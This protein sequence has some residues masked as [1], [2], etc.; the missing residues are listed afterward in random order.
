MNTTTLVLQRLGRNSDVLLAMGVFGLI[1]VM[2]VPLPSWVLDIL[3]AASF[4]S[5]I[6]MF[7]AVLTVKRPV[8]LSSFPILLLVSTVFR[9]G[10]NVAST[11]LVLLHGAHSSDAAGR[12]IEAFGQFVV[13]GEPIVGLVV[14]VILVVIN[15][16]VI[17]KGAGRVAEVSAR[18]VLDAM[19]GK[20]MAVDAELNAGLIDEKIAR[21]RRAEVSQEAEFY[22]AMDGASKFVRGDAI[23]GIAI[24]AI[25]ALGGIAIGTLQYG[26]P[27]TQVLH[28]FTILTIGDGLVAQVPS[29]IVS[30]AAG[31]L[32][33]RVNDLESRSLEHQVLSQLFSS[34]RTLGMVA[35][36]LG[37]MGLIPGL[38]LPFW[39]AA[40]LVG[41][42]AWQLSRN[43]MP[44]IDLTPEVDDSLPVAPP[45]PDE[46][47]PVEPLSIEI[48]GNLLYLVEGRGLPAGRSP[49]VIER[50]RRI[51]NQFA[52]DLGV[53][54]PS[55]HVRDDLAL[56]SGEYRIRLRGEEIGRGRIIPRQ[57]LA[58][59]PG[60]TSGKLAGTPTVDPA[61]GLPAYWISD[62]MVLKA[63]SM[64]YTVV[65][66]P[67]VITTHFVELM[68]GFAA[69]LFDGAQLAKA[70]E[71]VHANNP[72]L[73]DDLVPD[74]L[75]RTT[76]L[77]VFRNL[78]REGLSVRDAQSILEA[79][80]DHAARTR[81]PE[82]L[83]EFVRQRLSRQITRRFADRDGI[84]HYLGLAADAEDAV[85]RALQSAEGGAPT[86][87]LDPE[88]IRRLVARVRENCE[89][90]SGDGAAVL[91]APPLARGA[92]R[93]LLER[94]L[95]RVPVLSP[96]E[97][98]G[99]VKLDRIG[100]IDLR[101]APMQAARA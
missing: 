30:I 96:A 61:F 83:T 17:T 70:L 89:G 40:L 87:M 49:E 47:L 43:G 68:H 98:T 2:V 71:R 8:E 80:A 97:L 69:D 41:A 72:R 45:G 5:A 16:T 35:G 25:N 38:T 82:V 28:N 76:V 67:T 60:G 21:R 90:W 11:R 86:L 52:Q 33:T 32:V 13:G 84:V 92:V 39:S 74:P 85:L 77:K 27:L 26:M 15:F 88:Q 95:P 55:V 20:Q 3:I 99:N 12:I 29:L 100:V 22:G 19:P 31:L 65:D 24:T 34:P 93:R 44:V 79:L 59:D 42:L 1:A 75:A 36:L 14:F 73:V 48:A 50:I 4:G 66:V 18:F 94:V 56:P 46:L 53:V 63:Q 62:S 58:L 6:T 78:V 64:G 57:H 101:A 10:L 37:A 23:A 9:L 51:R 54:L 91:L 7:L 81:D